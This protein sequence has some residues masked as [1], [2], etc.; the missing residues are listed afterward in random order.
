MRPWMNRVPWGNEV[1]NEIITRENEMMNELVAVREW[2]IEWIGC[3]EWKKWS[4]W[5]NEIFN[6][7]ITRENETMN[8]LV[9]VREWNNE[10]ICCHERMKWSP[11]HNEI[12]NEI[13]TRE[14]EIMSS[15]SEGMKCSWRR[16][17]MKCSPWMNENSFHFIPGSWWRLP[18]A[19]AMNTSM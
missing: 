10:W 15:S 13:I 3:H 18:M 14:N 9:A 11:W 16:F 19:T 2:N 8:E 7:I 4:P 1:L 17:G 12:F 6:E 5:C